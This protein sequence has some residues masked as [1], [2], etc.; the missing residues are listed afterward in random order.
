MILKGLCNL[1]IKFYTFRILNIYSET[2]VN[3]M[4]LVL[5]IYVILGFFIFLQKNN[6][7]L[8]Q[9]YESDNVSIHFC[10]E[11]QLM[12]HIFFVCLISL[13]FN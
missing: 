12:Y 3:G 13:N 4:L 10:Y 8:D 2:Q 6:S 9:S 7:D 1:I 11:I 5:L